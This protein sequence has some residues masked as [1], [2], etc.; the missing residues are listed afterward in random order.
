MAP[1][2]KAAAVHQT[3]RTTLE[4]PHKLKKTNQKNVYRELCKVGRSLELT[5]NGSRGRA[6][7][8][9]LRAAGSHLN[10]AS[11]AEK[12]EENLKKF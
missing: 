11:K 8:A 10:P 12:L 7:A 5:S 4:K 3:Q 1:R 6:T 2:Q 9:V